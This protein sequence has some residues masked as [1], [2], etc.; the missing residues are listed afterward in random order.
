MLN[1]SIISLSYRRIP[2]TAGSM[3]T[4]YGWRRAS[5]CDHG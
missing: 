5:R 2:L 3:G 4:P 1:K